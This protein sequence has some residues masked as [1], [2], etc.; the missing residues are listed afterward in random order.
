VLLLLLPGVALIAPTPQRRRDDVHRHAPASIA[1]NGTMGIANFGYSEPPITASTPMA[2][3]AATPSA[4]RGPIITRT[5]P[6]K[7]TPFFALPGTNPNAKGRHLRARA[8]SKTEGRSC[9]LARELAF[10]LVD[11]HRL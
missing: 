9:I 10:G 11:E 8:G 3:M 6:C 5:C 2:I 4:T 7:S 1:T